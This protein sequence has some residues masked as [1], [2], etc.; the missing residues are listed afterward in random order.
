MIY[1]SPDDDD[2]DDDDDDND[3]DADCYQLVSADIR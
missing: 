3:D 2:D 1:N